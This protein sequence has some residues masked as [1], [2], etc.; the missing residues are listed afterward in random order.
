LSSSSAQ[1]ETCYGEPL[2]FVLLMHREKYHL[3]QQKDIEATELRMV[4]IASKMDKMFSQYI[5]LFK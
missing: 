2:L 1:Q 4:K 5:F 3:G